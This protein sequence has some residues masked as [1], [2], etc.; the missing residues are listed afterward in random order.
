MPVQLLERHH[1]K[2]E[3]RQ[4]NPEAQALLLQL[5]NPLFGLCAC[6]RPQ[7]YRI[8]SSMSDEMRTQRGRA[9]KK[10]VGLNYKEKES[11]KEA[12]GL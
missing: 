1:H 6:E 3:H 10:W 12:N 7:L 9:G 8:V 2:H 5:I 11:A 4:V